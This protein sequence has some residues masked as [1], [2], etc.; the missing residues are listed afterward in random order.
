MSRDFRAVF[1]AD[2]ADTF[3][4]MYSEFTTWREFSF[5][6]QARSY[7]IKRLLVVWNADVIK[8]MLPAVLYG[9]L[10]EGDVSFL[11]RC[12]DWPSRPRRNQVIWTPRDTPWNITRC[13]EIY[14]TC[15]RIVLQEIE[16]AT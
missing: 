3:L 1:Q 7:S 10:S 13:H 8:H 14:Q 11:T 4:G 5:Q 12:Q 16:S 15:Y 6:A 9:Q 2:V